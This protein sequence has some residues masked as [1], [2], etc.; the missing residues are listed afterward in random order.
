MCDGSLSSDLVALRNVKR[1][2]MPESDEHFGWAGNPKGQFTTTHWSLV[3]K[4]GQ[5]D[6]EIADQALETL[7]RIYWYPLYAYVRR[8]GYSE[9]DAQ[10]LTQGFFAILLE[11]KALQTVERRGGKFRSWLLASLNHFLNDEHDRRQTLKRG[12]GRPVLS[13]DAEAAELR[14]QL[15]SPSHETPDRL[16]DRRWATTLL[17]QAL[18]R[19]AQQFEQNGKAEEFKCLRGFLVEGAEAGPYVELAARLVISE[20]AARKVVQ[21]L[22]RAYRRAIR[23]EIAQTVANPADIEGELRE[24]WDTLSS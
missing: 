18:H 3:L 15:E 19:L 11:R 8:R 23:E 9:H 7:C 10:D 12:G 21:R 4:V 1:L 16:F 24:L 5:E 2:A 22:R 13:F 20:E 17:D 6:S 14:Y